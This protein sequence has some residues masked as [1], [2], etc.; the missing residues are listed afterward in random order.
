MRSVTGF[1]S[2][3]GMFFPTAQEAA[4]HDAEIQIIAW[5]VS[6]NIDQA[7][8][9]QII[10]A[11]ADPITEYVNALAV[12]EEI[13]LP[14]FIGN[15]AEASLTREDFEDERPSEEDLEA[16]LKQPPVRHEPMP[17]VGSG[18]RSEGV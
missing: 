12:E 18:S 14:K 1:L 8:V 15:H 9:F 17:D 13:D 5:C 16:I 2:E 6:H 10:E 4:K 11:L 3:D 7:K